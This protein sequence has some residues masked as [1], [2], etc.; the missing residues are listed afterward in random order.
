MSTVPSFPVRYEIE[1]GGTAHIRPVRPSDKALLQI[2]LEHVSRES[3]HRR[4]LSPM[5][6]FTRSQLEYL[7]EVDGKNHVALVARVERDGVHIGGGVGR[8]VRE[9]DD[10]DSA[11]FALTVTDEQQNEGLGTRLLELL[12]VMARVNGYKRLAG[13]VL[14][15]NKPM[16]AVLEKF[17]ATIRP[18]G[19]LLRGEIE[20]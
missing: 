6:S 16:L 17:G 2:G 5:P 18:D 3:R 19:D 12:I 13:L 14:R 8:Y 1:G 11:E 9:I 15:D 10:P 20:L 7:T 4:F